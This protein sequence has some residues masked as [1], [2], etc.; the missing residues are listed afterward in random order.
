MFPLAPERPE[1][2][3]VREMCNLLSII[4]LIRLKLPDSFPCDGEGENGK[5]ARFVQLKVIK[6]SP[7]NFKQ[8]REHPKDKL[9]PETL[10]KIKVETRKVFDPSREKDW[11]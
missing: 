9:Q 1:T 7:S 5:N 6:F 8:G 11:F 4:N 3:A 2:Q 10:G